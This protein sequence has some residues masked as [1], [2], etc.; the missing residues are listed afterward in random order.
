M[1]LY[2]IWYHDEWRSTD[3]YQRQAILSTTCDTT[4]WLLSHKDHWY[5]DETPIDD[6]VN[7]AINQKF[8]YMTVTRITITDNGHVTFEQ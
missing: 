1:I 6:I 4:N 2:E 3:T 5:D 7:Q 8:T